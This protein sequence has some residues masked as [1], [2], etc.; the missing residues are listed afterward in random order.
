MAERTSW[1]QVAK[2]EGF[3]VVFPD[4]LNRAWADL[5]P[6]GKREE[7][8]PSIG[9]LVIVFA[10]RGLVSHWLEVTKSVWRR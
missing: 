3:G 10:L 8:Q 2:R 5:R 4:G 9:L 6:S 7:V 1:P